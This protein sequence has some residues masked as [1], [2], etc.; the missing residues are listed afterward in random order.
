MGV[1]SGLPD[2]RGRDGFW[3]AYP[4]LAKLGLSFEQMANAAL[5]DR[6]PALAW[7][8]YGHRLNL[9]RR[10][11]PHAGFT[12]LLRCM[13]EKPGGGFVFT[14]NV[15]GHFQR[16]GFPAGSVAECHGSIHHFQCI[17]D[18]Q[19]EL[20][21]APE[22][23]G[24]TVDQ[25]TCRAV[26]ELPRCPHC[27]QLARPNIMMFLDSTWQ[28]QRSDGQEA[29]YARWLWERD[30]TRLAVIEL[31]AGT[32]IA[33]VRRRGEQ[34]QREGATLI[35]INPRESSGPPGTISLEAGALQAI[36]AL[37]DLVEGR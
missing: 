26:G 5:F 11:P 23:L 1:D 33:T 37:A 2:F 17:D 31:G 29:A 8:F 27:G 19:R 10:T 12:K 28:P 14:S 35:R 22:Q 32:T 25:A 13:E 30:P 16:A 3:R 21:P 6:D 20:W 34:L 15:D 4:P 24:F 7:G 36:Q 9:Y 18:C